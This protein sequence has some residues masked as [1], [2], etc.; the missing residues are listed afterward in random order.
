MLD[1]PIAVHVLRPL[2]F[3]LQN[4][5]KSFINEIAISGGINL[6]TLGEHMERNHGFADIEPV[7]TEPEFLVTR[8]KEI[9]GEC[10][11]LTNDMPEFPTDRPLRF[12]EIARLSPER[13]E[14]VISA[15]IHIIVSSEIMARI[16]TAGVLDKEKI[17]LQILIEAKLAFDKM[18]KVWSEMSL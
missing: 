11:L 8:P 13:N 10:E 6:Y 4:L 12:Q 18:Y 14:C 15:A 3:L 7:R 5:C 2:V 9:N 1:S 17:R 16:N